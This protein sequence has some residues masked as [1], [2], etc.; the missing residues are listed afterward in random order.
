MTAPRRP[1]EPSL[2]PIPAQVI[3]GRYLINSARGF[4]WSLLVAEIEAERTV[5]APNPWSPEDPE[6]AAA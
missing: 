2:D 6:G 1:E 3:E 5:P 4:R